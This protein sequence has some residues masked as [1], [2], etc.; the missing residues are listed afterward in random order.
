MDD[1]D[2]PMTDPDTPHVSACSLKP[3]KLFPKSDV[4]EGAALLKAMAHNGRLMILCQLSEGEK[5]VSELERVV[6]L[7]QA[8]VSQQRARLRRDGLV[9]TRREG[10]VIFY[11][12]ED[13]RTKRL[14]ETLCEIFSGREDGAH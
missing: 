12:I 8:A 13:P 2:P 3:E 1:H 4:A 14:L 9:A 6:A 5:S 11:A 10:K 7:R